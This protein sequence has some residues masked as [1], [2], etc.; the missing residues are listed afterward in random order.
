MPYLVN[1]LDKIVREYRDLI[2]AFDCDP[3]KVGKNKLSYTTAL[4]LFT[5]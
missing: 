4:R 3:Q 1:N 5:D 2:I